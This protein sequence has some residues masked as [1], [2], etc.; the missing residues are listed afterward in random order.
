MHFHSQL[1]A[2]TPDSSLSA[3]SISGEFSAFILEDGFRMQKVMH[4]TRIA[5]GL[6][7]IQP[8]REG[9]I[10]ESCR[11]RFG[12]KFVPHIIG[13]PSFTWILIH[14]GITTEDTSG[15]LLPGFGAALNRKAKRFVLSDS[16]DAFLAICKRMESPFESGEEVTIRISRELVFSEQ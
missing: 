12:V 6:Y 7:Q 10:F 2:E 13:V 1:I 4:Q 5:P 14:P 11:R 16:A 9:R 15:C 3:V 8:R